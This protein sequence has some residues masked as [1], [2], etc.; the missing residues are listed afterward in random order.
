MGKMPKTARSKSNAGT[1]DV[2]SG[3]T[4]LVIKAKNGSTFAF[5]QLVDM[6]QQDIFRMVYYRIR[7]HVDAEDITQEVFI[8]AFKNL[9]GLKAVERFRSWLFRIAL[10]RVRDHYRKKRFQALFGRFNEEGAPI[11]SDIEPNDNP[12]AVNRLL[13]RDFWKQVSLFTDKLSRMEREVF[14]LRFFDQLSIK[15]IAGVLKKSESTVK[16]HL[17]RSLSKFKT[18]PSLHKLR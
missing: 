17:Y 10:N 6:F 15:E 1:S 18:E 9:T 2:E 7:S 12:E 11:Q 4:S 8:Q 14:L 13:K 5:D 3:I 16:T